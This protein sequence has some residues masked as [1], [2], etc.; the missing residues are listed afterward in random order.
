MVG[1]MAPQAEEQKDAEESEGIVKFN[2]SLLFIGK[3]QITITNEIGRGSFGIVFR[4]I[5]SGTDVAIKEIKARNVKRLKNVVET[6]MQVHTIVRHRNIT[7][8]MAVS[9]EK[10]HV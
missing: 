7:Q 5:W 9:I 6:E 8:I 2:R 3:D 1:T 10:N 4:R